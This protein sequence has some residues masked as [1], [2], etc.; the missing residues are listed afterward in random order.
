MPDDFDYRQLL[1]LQRR[2]TLR[3]SAYIEDFLRNPQSHLKTSAGLI[4][5][6]IRHFGVEI[7]VRAGEPA[8]S[9]AVFK[10]EP[11]NGVNAVYG[12]EFCIKHIVDVID[13]IDKE[14][15]P[16]RGI[17]LFGPPASGKT[18]ICDLI[19][20]ALEAYTRE[21]ELRSYSF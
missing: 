14:A 12:Q 1:G 5:E 4:S 7:V 16:K 18:N 10:D 15:G 21:T 6:A 2:N 9:Y 20:Q 13:S 19:A 17:V 8:L 3:F 11:G